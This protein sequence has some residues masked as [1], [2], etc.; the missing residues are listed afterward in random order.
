[1]STTHP[2]SMN[3]NTTPANLAARHSTPLKTKNQGNTKQPTASTSN[4]QIRNVKQ[5]KIDIRQADTN[6]RRSERGQLETS[7][8]PLPSYQEPNTKSRTAQ[9]LP[10][11]RPFQPST[12]PQRRQRVLENQ[13][14]RR[15]GGQPMSRSKP[16]TNAPSGIGRLCGMIK[17]AAQIVRENYNAGVEAAMLESRSQRPRR[18]PESRGERPAT[19]RREANTDKPSSLQ[20]RGSSTRRAP[21]TSQS[22]QGPSFALGRS[23]SSTREAVR[24]KLEQVRH[25]PPKQVMP[26]SASETL[27]TICHRRGAV[28]YKETSSNPLCRDCLALGFAAGQKS[29]PQLK[30][31]HINVSDYAAQVVMPAPLKINRKHKDDRCT[32]LPTQEELAAGTWGVRIESS[33]TT[34]SAQNPSPQ[35]SSPP[36]KTP[37]TG[38][39]DPLPPTLL[40][41]SRPCPQSL[42]PLLCPPRRPC[43]RRGDRREVP[44]TRARY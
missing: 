36:R 4:I 43:C 19:A 23:S 15:A 16:E 2:S 14:Q 3:P 10:A 18:A 35:R 40:P 30:P 11:R 8:P 7:S 5:A 25:A 12:A 42:I 20:T 24:T 38:T 32:L 6:R 26:K 41:P 22:D 39:T 44:Q 29:T 9:T 31:S 1:M 33:R 27:C 13:I 17:E 37:V 34:Q 28:V 21:N